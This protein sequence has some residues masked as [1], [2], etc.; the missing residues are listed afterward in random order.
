MCG[1][2][3]LTSN[4]KEKL[5][6][7]LPDATASD[8]HGNRYNITPGQLIPVIKSLATPRVEWLRWGLIPAWA[9]DPSIA[10]KLINARSETVAEK[11]AFRHAFTTRRCLVL[12]NGYYEWQAGPGKSSPKI[13]YYFHF[14]GRELFA[15]AGLWES[16]T[17][18]EGEGIETCTL[19]TKAANA[20]V[21]EI[22][23]R[24]PAL[25][26][27]AMIPAWLDPSTSTDALHRLFRSAPHPRLQRYPVSPRVNRASEDDEGLIEPNDDGLPG[28]QMTLF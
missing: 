8:W 10:W 1:R 11:P 25:L 19:I 17:S 4:K 18:P 9:D 16:W 21:A 13:P 2:L 5:T 23:H 7:L 3:T 24:M 22:H 15:I 14:P 27:P 6:D 12:A 20:W 28:E 26:D